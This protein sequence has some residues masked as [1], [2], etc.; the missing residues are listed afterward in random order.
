[1]TPAHVLAVYA[2][3]LVAGRRV[4]LLGPEDPSL[5]EALLALGARVLYVYDPRPQASGP[6]RG[7][8]PRVTIA[9]LRAGDLG[10]REGAFDLAL[11][12]DLGQLGDAESALAYVRR[13]VGNAGTAVLGSR[14]ADAREPWTQTPEGTTAPTYTEFYDLC[15][16]QFAEVRMAG[17]APFAAYAVAEF[18]P[19]REPS[20][21]FDASLVANPDPPEWFVAVASQRAESVLEAYEIVQIPREAVAISSAEAATDPGELASTRLRLT[22]TE[23]KCQQAEARAGEEALRADRAIADAR[24]QAEE[25]R[26]LREKAARQAKELEDERRLRQRADS[27]LE[28]TRKNPEVAQLRERTLALEAE[29]IEART[30][31]ATPRA[32]AVDPRTKEER[33]ALAAELAQ[34]KSALQ[35]A[36]GNTE[37]LRR[38]LAERDRELD[39]SLARAKS[40]EDRLAEQ[41]ADS[42]RKES[43]REGAQQL[44]EQ[45]AKAQ[46]LIA[47]LGSELE[48]LQATHEHDVATLEAALRARGEEL[49]L[50]RS[51][52]LRRERMIREL[53]A[54]LEAGGAQVVPVATGGPSPEQLEQIE[55]ARRELATLVE[56]VRRRDRALAE[57]KSAL[58][59]L[60]REIETERGKTERLARDAARREAA[61][62]TASWRIAELEKLGTEAEPAEGA[63]ASHFDAELDA[64][65]RA[66]AQEHA[67]VEELER[68]LS[69]GGSGDSAELARVL[70]R[71]QEREALIA[72]LSAELAARDAAAG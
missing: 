7:V 22:A 25:L 33:D 32:P 36:N 17:V 65:R 63:R 59:T 57:A 55:L 69:A 62:Q 26:K 70:A 40:L 20:I 6:R 38:R 64:L 3:P 14:N 72:Q 67:R 53:V 29:L 41:L 10:V 12:P 21:A 51:E 44:H 39:A 16:L 28:S 42:A 8:D 24:A 48:S 5:V 27:D 52:L 1:M 30:Q 19:E 54:Q 66:L 9:P 43:E 2:E 45:L 13:L 58:D 37:D 56:E 4:A 23:Q 15:A 49:R 35:Q 61:L 46:A 18:A 11:V 71:L 68:Q 50:A 60:R 31:L 34:A 47:R